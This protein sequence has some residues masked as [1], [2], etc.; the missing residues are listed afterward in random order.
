[1]IIAPLRENGTEVQNA[2]DQTETSTAYIY[3]CFPVVCC[4]QFLPNGNNPDGF[5]RSFSLQARERNHLAAVARWTNPMPPTPSAKKGLTATPGNSTCSSRFRARGSRARYLLLPTLDPI[6]A[7]N[8]LVS[9]IASRCGVA[10]GSSGQRIPCMHVR[11]GSEAEDACFCGACRGRHRTSTACDETICPRFILRLLPPVQN[12]M[13]LRET[14]GFP[15]PWSASIYI[16]TCSAF[17]K[18]H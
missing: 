6:F 5:R 3:T 17:C 18:C 13:H 15:Q 7:E 11:M 12:V 8:V 4:T 1:M 16:H 9:T 2:Q 14:G 10:F